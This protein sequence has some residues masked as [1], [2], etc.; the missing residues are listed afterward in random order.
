MLGMIFLH[1]EAL[2][3]D[4]L[5][6]AG[7]LATGFVWAVEGCQ[8]VI[9]ETGVLG[10]RVTDPGGDHFV[11]GDLQ[12]NGEQDSLALHEDL[13]GCCRKEV[14]GDRKPIRGTT[15]RRGTSDRWRRDMSLRD[16]SRH[17]KAS[18]AVLGKIQTCP[19]ITA[20]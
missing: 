19:K 4:H 2:P 7:L 5:A 14:P 6:A 20:L 1:V 15:V 3:I 8:A 11:L 13:S 10:Q 16:K 17:P 12:V 9:E 18:T